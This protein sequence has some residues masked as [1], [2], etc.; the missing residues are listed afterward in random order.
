MCPV[1]AMLY[2]SRLVGAHDLLTRLDQGLDT[3]L[4]ERRLPISA[5]GHP[6][7][8]RAIGRGLGR[9]LYAKGVFR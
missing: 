4:G 6:L 7:D 2:Q 8:A 1:H 5:G 9:A 3:S